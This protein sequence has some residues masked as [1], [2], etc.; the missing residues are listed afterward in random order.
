MDIAIEN[1]AAKDKAYS[2]Q[3]IL[4]EIWLRKDKDAEVQIIRTHRFDIDSQ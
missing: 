4:S 3:K 1:T 2:T